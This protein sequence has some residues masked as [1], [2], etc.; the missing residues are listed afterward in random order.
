LALESQ[1]TNR[2]LKY[3]NG[4]EDCVAEKVMGNAFQFGRPDINA[5]WKGRSVRIEVKTPDHG[6]KPS[7]AQEL[8]LRQWSKAGALAFVAYSLEDV[9]E[10]IFDGVGD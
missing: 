5:C 9:K 1:I 4:L 2:I 7:K 6:N 10:R 3:L 8:N